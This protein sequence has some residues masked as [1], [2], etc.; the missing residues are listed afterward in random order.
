MTVVTWF[1]F[2]LGASAWALIVFV[3]VSVALA[4]RR[5]GPAVAPLLAMFGAKGPSSSSS[6]AAAAAQ[7]VSAL[8]RPGG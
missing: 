5:I 8:E 6:S 2:A 4:W 1:A 7:D 3:G